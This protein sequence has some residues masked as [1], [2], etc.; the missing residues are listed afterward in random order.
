MFG[1]VVD[2]SGQVV[3]GASITYPNGVYNTMFVGDR[4]RTGVDAVLQWQPADDFEA[5]AEA[6]SEDFDWRQNQYTFTT[7]G[8]PSGRMW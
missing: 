4:R 1:S 6:S 7:S 2:E 3:P 5:Y 8:N